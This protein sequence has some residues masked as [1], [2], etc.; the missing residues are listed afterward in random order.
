MNYDGKRIH[1]LRELRQARVRK[2]ARR[3]H[4]V[5]GESRPMSKEY[6]LKYCDNCNGFV[7]AHSTGICTRC[8]SAKGI[9]Q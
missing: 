1:V 3:L 7:L 9:K 5:L 4:A 2:P 8:D 6:D